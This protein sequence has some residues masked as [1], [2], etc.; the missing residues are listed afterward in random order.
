MVVSKLVAVM[1]T[2]L[3][4]PRPA[5][6]GLSPQSTLRSVTSDPP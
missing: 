5:T 1:A 6:M 2:I 3:A 4:A